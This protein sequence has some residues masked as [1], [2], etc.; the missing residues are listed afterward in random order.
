MPLPPYT[1]KLLWERKSNVKLKYNHMFM[2]HAHITP[3]EG[4]IE[5]GLVCAVADRKQLVSR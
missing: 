2:C 1:W 3:A 5:V 4:A